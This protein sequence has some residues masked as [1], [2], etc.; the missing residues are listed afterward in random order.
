MD[1]YADMA[2]QRHRERVREI[3]RYAFLRQIAAS[4]KSRSGKIDKGLSVLGRWMVGTGKRLQ[5]HYCGE[6]DSLDS[7][8]IKPSLLTR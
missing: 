3:E 7:Q 5:A 1:W 6:K 4:T 2:V 8:Y